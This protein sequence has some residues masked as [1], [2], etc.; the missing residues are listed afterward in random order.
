MKPELRVITS[1]A[2]GTKRL[3]EEK[4]IS[5]KPAQG[6]PWSVIVEPEKK[7]QPMLGF[8]GIWT[9][10]DLYMVMRMSPEKQEEV[11]RATFDRENGAGWSFMRLPFGST[12]WET[13]VDYY[14]YDDVPYGEKDWE[15]KNFSIQRDIDR[16]FF[17]LAKRC[18]EI[19]PELQFLGSVWGVP[20]W[21]KENNSIMF[22]RFN[23]E[24]TEVYAKYLCKTIQAFK[25]QGVELLAVTPQNES[26]TSD[27]RATPACRFTWRMQRDVV[28]ALKKELKEAGLNTEVWFYD[29]NFDMSD[30]FVKPML[31]KEETRAL[32]DGVAFHDYGGS[33]K[34][35]GALHKAYPDMPFYMTE[36]TVSTVSGMGNIVEQLCN[37][38]RSYIQWSMF[39]DEYHGPHQYLGNPFVYRKPFAPENLAFIYNEKDNA[40]QW[41]YTPGYGL[42]SQFTKF[43][44][45]GM[46][47]VESNYG[48]RKWI[49][50]TAFMN[51]E[52][53]QI[54]VILVNETEAAQPV[55]IICNGWQSDF[56]LEKEAIATCLL[57]GY[58]NADPEAVTVDSNPTA[59]TSPVFAKEPA[60]DLEPQEVL[61]KG[62]AKQGAE[63]LFGCRVKNVGELP[64]PEGATLFV[65]FMLD[66]DCGIGRSIVPCP[67]LQQGDETV[68]WV[69]VPVGMKR[70]WDAEGGWHNIFAYAELGGCGPEKNRDNNRLG[71]EIYFA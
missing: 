42:Y 69:N 2:A 22:G 31:E 50:N 26:L 47:R 20:A 39:T 62:E 23:P 46:V 7:D 54:A 25:E 59:F 71:T 1:N 40:D 32:I 61:M 57:S 4:E 35:M 67:V 11:L 55:S 48:D 13:T 45:P 16:G 33:P 24:C 41:H 9:D 56:I 53:G 5:M 34:V 65:N 6:S 51:Q 17:E 10:T 28:A 52:T 49:T 14:T 63:V 68:A 21:M 37:G 12:D 38:A 70:E 29:H 8:G 30:D 44:R 19:N 36:R 64:T 60:W 3:Y 58:E 27:D 43:L 18:K 15:L 66:G